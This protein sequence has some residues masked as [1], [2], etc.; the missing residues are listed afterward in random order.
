MSEPLK[1]TVDKLK[2]LS[3]HFCRQ[4]YLESKKKCPEPIQADIQKIWHHKI[5]FFLR[6]QSQPITNLC[7]ETSQGKIVY[8]P[9]LEK[10]FKHQENHRTQQALERKLKTGVQLLIKIRRLKILIRY[11]YNWQNQNWLFWD[12]V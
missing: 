11:R 2:K 12:C 10:Q 7:P 5:R 8:Q 3:S 4:T 6:M 1:N 9:R